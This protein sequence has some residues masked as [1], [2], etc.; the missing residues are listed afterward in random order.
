[1]KR[2]R[3]KNMGWNGEAYDPINK[4]LLAIFMFG[5]V[6]AVFIFTA[7]TFFGLTPR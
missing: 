4:K 2:I 3:Q 7:I 1:M 5:V 6:V